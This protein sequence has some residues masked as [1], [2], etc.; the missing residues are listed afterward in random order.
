VT[1]P[2]RVVPTISLVLWPTGV[3]LSHKTSHCYMFRQN[4][5]IFRA[6]VINV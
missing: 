2:E 6:S 5:V 1:G 3:P 4:R